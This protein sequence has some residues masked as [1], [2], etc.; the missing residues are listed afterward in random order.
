MGMRCYG[1]V[2]SPHRPFSGQTLDNDWLKTVAD[3]MRQSVIDQVRGALM[4]SDIYLV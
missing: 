2:N 1:Y 4:K 3:A